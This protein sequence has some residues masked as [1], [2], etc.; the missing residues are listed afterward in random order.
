MLARAALATGIIACLSTWVVGTPI[1]YFDLDD[2]TQ[3]IFIND[4]SFRGDFDAS[5][6]GHT[7]QQDRYRVG[8][9]AQRLAYSLPLSWIQRGLTLKPWQVENLLRAV[10][11]VFGLG[12]SLLAAFA[13]LPAPRFGSGA[14]LTLVAALAAHPS[15]ALCART[16]ASFY[17]F[18]YALFWLGTL[19]AFRWLD[20]GRPGWILAAAGVATLSAL[21]PYPPLLCWP[22][23][24]A[25]LALWNG[26][27]TATLRSRQLW[28]ATALALIAACAATAAMA[29]AYDTSLSTFLERLANFRSDRGHAVAF[30]QLVSA[31]PLEKLT[32]LVNQQWLFRF[33]RLGDL[34]R[35][36]RAWTLGTL[37]PAVLVWGLVAAVGLVAALRERSPEDRRALSITVAVLLLF[38]SFSFP[39]GRYV[40]ALLPCWGYFGLR[41]VGHL[42]RRDTPR[43]FTLAV[44]LLLLCGITEYCIK[45]TY[46]P[47][48][49]TIWQNH[50]GM[51]EIAPILA[52]LPGSR[53]ILMWMP[54]RHQTTTDLH[55][56]MLMP[57]GVEW[58]PP[59][60]F[61]RELAA[62]QQGVR[63]GA[64]TYADEPGRLAQFLGRGFSRTAKL[65]GEA[66]GRELW[67]L[68]R[69]PVVPAAAGPAG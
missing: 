55:F 25:L 30:S 26:R 29:A 65:R 23:G 3:G 42:V 4:L 39:E 9:A 52:A 54:Y 27:L 7:D 37:Q 59:E 49:R 64:L 2:A 62:P 22:L 18:A 36:D 1:S 68:L 60:R 16:G 44:S 43:Q 11:L 13:L 57:Q 69:E 6:E 34:S 32:K 66:S 17:L 5:F 47:R 20:N 40:L 51:R 10:A 15:L 61:A 63:F 31:G 38:F 45:A 12:G 35:G 46:V 41:G 8:F 48:I 24:A 28:A 19:A 21:N 33:D 53:G 50:E 56:R 67:L 58:V 14:R